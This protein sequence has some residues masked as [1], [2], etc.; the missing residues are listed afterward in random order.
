M[1]KRI[2]IVMSVSVALMCGGVPMRTANAVLM[3]EAEVEALNAKSAEP[4]RA[5][6]T[7]TGKKNENGFVRALKAPFKAIG[8]LFGFGNKNEKKISRMREKDAKK[9]ESATVTR[10]IDARMVPPD[11]TTTRPSA[12][13]P[14]IDAATISDEEA[15]SIAA[16]EQLEY[17][18]QLLNSGDLNGA[19]AALSTAV[20]LNPKLNDAHNLMGVAYEAKGLRNLAF[21]S[22]ELALRGDN[23]DPEHVN[24]L[25]YLFYKNGEYENALK[26]LKRAVKRAPENQRYW[27]NLGLA[28]AQLRKFDD[29]YKSFA[30]AN[31]ELEGH[32]NIATKLQRV[33]RE[34]EAI[35][36][37]ERA[38][39]LQ[40]KS[41]EI[42]ARLVSLYERT[43]RASE[44]QEARASITTLRALATTPKD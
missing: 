37:L 24:N 22:F 19:I 27:N 33:G 43:G 25:G 32:L 14:S 15:K 42:L 16:R 9:F 4:A 23:D 12:D 41:T 20:S 35:K 39:S 17:G 1:F 8:R 40:P 11:Q 38:R 18:R 29:A 6:D 10:V 36:H 28:Q 2:C 31:G 30:R 5:S 34:D 26:Y 21:K 44:A 13:N 3:T 7:D